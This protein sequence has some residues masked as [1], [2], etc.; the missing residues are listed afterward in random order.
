MS[1]IEVAGLVL[2]ALPLLI[3]AVEAYQSSLD[4][5]TAF[6]K[7]KDELEKA[8]RELWVQHSYFE[9]TLRSLLQQV[10][11]PAEVD[12]MISDFNSSLWKSPELANRLK[13][14]L[15]TAYKVYVYTMGEME[16]Y[17]VTLASHLDI[18]RQQ[19]SF[20]SKSPCDRTG[21]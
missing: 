19:V 14:K 3:A 6:F 10:A 7:W 12:A 9:L 11:G 20:A 8:M 16:G 13:S 4:P 18:D 21:R 2:G 15:Q 17:M 5:L 1:G